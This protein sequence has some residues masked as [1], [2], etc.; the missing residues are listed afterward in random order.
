MLLGERP[1]RPFRLVQIRHA[2]R[3]PANRD[4]CVIPFHNPNN[5]PISDTFGGN[6]PFSEIEMKSWKSFFEQ[7]AQRSKLIS[8]ISIHNYGQRILSSY[9]VS[10]RWFPS[11]RIK[12][13]N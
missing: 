11:K 3:I 7:A 12:I 5:M 1:V 10:R 8:Y 4:Y 9:A 2:T 6:V 13:S